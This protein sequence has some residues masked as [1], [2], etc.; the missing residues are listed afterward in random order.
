MLQMLSLTA[1][2]E[3]VAK[4]VASIAQG[5][6]ALLKLQ[7]DKPENEKLANAL[8]LKQEGAMNTVSFSMPSADVVELLKAGAARKAQEG[9]G[10]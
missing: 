8:S 10:K 6:V 1:T 7:K 2:D 3:E 5:L 9:D 4:N